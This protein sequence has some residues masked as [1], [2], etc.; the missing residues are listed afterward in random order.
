MARFESVSVRTNWCAVGVDLVS[1][2]V[3]S[4]AWDSQ[5]MGYM[6]EGYWISTRHRL[7]DA[8]YTRIMSPVCAVTLPNLVDLPVP[9]EV[10]CWRACTPV[11]SGSVAVQRHCDAAAPP[12]VAFM[13]QTQQSATS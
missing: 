3:A 11:S 10:A 5:V 13:L 8:R 4:C 12:C 6:A 9:P 1:Q 7:L 2:W